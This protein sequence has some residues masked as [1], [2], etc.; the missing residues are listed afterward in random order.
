MKRMLLKFFALLMLFS[1]S[2]YAQ[3]KELPDPSKSLNPPESKPIWIDVRT[4]GE[5]NYSHLE[6]SINIP[7]DIITTY[8][9]ST[10]PDKSADIRVYCRSGRRSGIAKEKLEGIGYTNVT[11]EGGMRN[12]VQSGK[13]KVGP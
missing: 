9:V 1:V 6:G 11:N 12:I 5:Y 10:A 4:K 3:K 8:I 13:K 7:Y 2:L